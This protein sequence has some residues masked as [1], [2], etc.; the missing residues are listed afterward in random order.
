MRVLTLVILMAI[1]LG[2]ALMLMSR[3]KK[4][5]WVEFLILMVAGLVILA[6]FF[7][8]WVDAGWSYPLMTILFALSLANILWLYTNVSILGIFG[9]AL[10]ANVTGVVLSMTKIDKELTMD[11]LIETYD[12]G[13]PELD[14]SV[15][16]EAPKAKKKAK[17]RRKK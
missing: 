11:E 1:N 2:A 8:M 7:G 5:W 16:M 14:H 12:V 6:G 4:F 15:V 3:M 10:L 17:K 13:E 9:L